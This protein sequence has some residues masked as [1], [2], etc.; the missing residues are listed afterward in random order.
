[1]IH[2]QQTMTCNFT[3]DALSVTNQVVC[4]RLQL[5]HEI[6]MPRVLHAIYLTT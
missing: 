3:E 5:P 6:K 4:C 2:L 1:M